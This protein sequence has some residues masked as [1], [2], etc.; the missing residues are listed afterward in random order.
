MDSI[1]IQ[2][3]TGLVSALVGGGG[4]A[5]WFSYRGNKNKSI[6]DATKELL[7]RYAQDN[8]ILKKENQ[9]M[10]DRLNSL[11]V[12]VVLLEASTQEYPFPVWLKDT[13]G[14]ILA[15]NKAYEDMFLLPRGYKS[16]DC[17]GKKSESVWP[18]EIAVADEDRARWVIRTKSTWDENAELPINGHTEEW[19]IIKFPRFSAGI[20]IGTLGMAIPTYKLK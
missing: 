18:P 5:A 3:L 1:L 2:S 8:E 11:E 12:K 14:T 9:Q 17:V 19:R 4:V 13:D 15:V 10:R 20:I 16:S 7:D 6:A